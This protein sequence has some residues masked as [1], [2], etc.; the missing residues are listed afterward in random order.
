MEH[1]DSPTSITKEDT[2]L[3]IPHNGHSF[4]I[5]KILDYQYK[6]PLATIFITLFSIFKEVILKLRLLGLMS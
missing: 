4:K 6:S 1:S 5:I 3:V 2:V